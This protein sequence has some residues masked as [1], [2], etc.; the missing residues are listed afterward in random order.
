MNRR[1][2]LKRTGILTG[3]AILTPTLL[4][5]M[6]SCQAED[7]LE[8]Q[9]LFLDQDEAKFIATFVDTILPRT[10]TP[11]ALDV[12]VDMFIDR[13]VAETY[14]K[15]GQESFRQEIK[16]FNEECTRDFGA[17]FAELSADKK[18]EV[19][20]AAEKTSGQ[21][22]GGVWGTAVG[23]QKPIGFYRSLKSMSIWLYFSSEEIGENVLNYDPI[24]Q[25]YEGCLN[26]D[27]IGNRWSL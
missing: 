7:R 17:P 18:A 26:V 22:N 5:I 3:A 2:A 23:E 24:P 11:G 9:P 13:L 16:K 27:D 1:N 20:Q 19:C 15:G 12:K 25:K 6:Q 14:D 8:W 21:F 4:T 10:K